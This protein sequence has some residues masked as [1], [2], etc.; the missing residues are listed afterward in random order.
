MSGTTVIRDPYSDAAQRVNSYGK[1]QVVAVQR[2]GLHNWAEEGQA[3]MFPLEKRTLPGTAEYAVMRWSF[4]DPI[5]N[6]HLVRM[7]VG[8]NGGT[9]NHNRCLIMRMYVGMSAPS[10]NA[11]AYSPINL[12]VGNATPALG[13]FHGW[14]GVG[15]GMTVA[16]N[17]VIGMTEIYSQGL[18]SVEW[19]AGMVL[20]NGVVMGLTVQGEEVG[21]FSLTAVGYFAEDKF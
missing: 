14:D 16:S 3:Y 9:T 17:G 15:N 13:D 5:N 7:S 1:A 20:P 2:S 19:D 8:W 11:T 4:T 10:A 12:Y 6:G 21:D 18:T